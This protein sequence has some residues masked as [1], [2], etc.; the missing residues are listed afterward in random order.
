MNKFELIDQTL[1]QRACA[2]AS[3]AL[4]RRKNYNFHAGDDEACHRLLNAME[5]DSY[6]PP[7]CHLDPAKDE[8]ILVLKGRFGL[9]LFAPDGKIISTAILQ[10]GGDTLGVNILHGQFHTLV[11]LEE[12]SVFFE[13]K[14]GPYQPL[15]VDE[16]GSW[17]PAEEAPDAVEYLVKLKELFVAS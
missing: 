9:V 10:A 7:H 14:A 13:S 4:R 6:I 11:A 15:T 3:S 8:S 5:P 1:L 2:A 16:K 17:A 12:G